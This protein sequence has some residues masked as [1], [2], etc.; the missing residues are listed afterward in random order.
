MKTN[1]YLD[2]IKTS[3]MVRVQKGEYVAYSYYDYLGLQ[4]FGNINIFKK[5]QCL[6]HATTETVYGKDELQKYLADFIAKK[7]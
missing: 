6:L 3:N 5:Q 1:T 4:R 7:S 2:K